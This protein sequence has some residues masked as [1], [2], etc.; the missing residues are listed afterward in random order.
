MES[1][2]LNSAQTWGFR[3]FLFSLALRS[4]LSVTLDC[5]EDAGGARGCLRSGYCSSLDTQP[6]PFPNFSLKQCLPRPLPRPGCVGSRDPPSSRLGPAPR[7]H[8]PARPC[9]RSAARWRPPESTL[10]RRASKPWSCPRA[11]RKKEGAAPL[12]GNPRGASCSRRK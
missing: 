4:D 8:G 9:S 7:S 10:P 5:P 11:A 12:L 3:G 6:Q 1:I 2:A